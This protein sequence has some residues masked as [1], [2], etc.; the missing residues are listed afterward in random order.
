MGKWFRGSMLLVLMLSVSTLGVTPSQASSQASIK[1]GSKCAKLGSTSVFDGKTYTCVK[2]GKTLVWDSGIK[3]AKSAPITKT[4]PI[5]KQV[6]SQSPAAAATPTPTPSTSA[7]PIATPSATPT[8]TPTPT[9]TAT[10]KPSPTGSVLLGSKSKPAAIG[11][12]IKIDDITYAITKVDFNVDAKICAANGQ[13]DGCTV[14]ANQNSIVVPTNTTTWVDVIFNVQNLATVTVNPADSTIDFY[15][16]IPNEPL[17]QNNDLVFGYTLLSDLQI[18]PGGSGEGSVL[19]QVPKTFKTLKTT[20][21]LRTLD[22]Y[23][24]PVD[25][26]FQVNW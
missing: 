20:L 5:P 8:A 26:Y 25:T 22:D 16:V 11:S 14:D 18:D 19:F 15:L 6:V 9:A 4:T 23:G 10:P 3:V 2:K 13:N 1:S 7:I 17:L 21:D 24:D 12:S